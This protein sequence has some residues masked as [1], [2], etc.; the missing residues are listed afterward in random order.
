MN[1]REQCFG[2]IRPLFI[3]DKDYK[4][5]YYQGF[6]SSFPAGNVYDDTTYYLNVASMEASDFFLKNLPMTVKQ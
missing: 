5:E 1:D 4:K 6:D 2:K 3:S